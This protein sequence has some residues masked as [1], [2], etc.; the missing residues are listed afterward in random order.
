I[1]PNGWAL[2][3]EA[4]AQRL[5][6]HRRRGRA[7][8]AIVRLDV[9]DADSIAA[10]SDDGVVFVAHRDGISQVDLRSRTVSSVSVPKGLS[11]RRLGRIRWRSNHLIGLQIK[12]DDGSR[13]IIRLDLNRNGNA[14]TR[15]TRLDVP[16]P[17]AG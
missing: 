5:L 11:L 1:G 15:V 4:R 8:A 14:I 10:A 17:A 12:D 2:P 3:R 9:Q 6:L 7:L 16:A 13:E